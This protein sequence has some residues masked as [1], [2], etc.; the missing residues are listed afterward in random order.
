MNISIVPGF[1]WTEEA[2]RAAICQPRKSVRFSESEFIE[3][4]VS[5][6]AMVDSVSESEKDSE[7]N[8][9]SMSNCKSWERFSFFSGWDRL[10]ASYRESCA[11]RCLQSAQ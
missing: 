2:L 3:S 7:E 10:V 8:L 9:E 1:C 6:A 5:L 11:N 4:V